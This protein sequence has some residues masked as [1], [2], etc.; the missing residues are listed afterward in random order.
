[1]GGA[2]RMTADLRGKKT[3]TPMRKSLEP[4]ALP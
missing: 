1:M 3:G 2:W 4:T